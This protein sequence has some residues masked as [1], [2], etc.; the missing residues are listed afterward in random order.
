MKTYKKAFLGSVVATA[1]SSSCV[2]AQDMTLRFSH[3]LP[4]QHALPSHG[5]KNWMES[6]SESSNGSINFQ[7][8]PSQQLGSAADHYD[9]AAMGIADVAW[10]NTGY[11]AGRFPI[12]DALQLPF[13]VNNNTKDAAV[14]ATEWY[15]NYAQSEMSEVI[16][17]VMHGHYPGSLHSK[18]E[19]RS[20]EQISGMTIR[21]AGS[22]IAQLVSSLGGA[23]VQVPPP[24]AREALARGTADAITFPYNSARLFDI[25]QIVSYSIDYPIYSSWQAI[26]INKSAYERM[27]EEQKQVIDSHCT[28]EWARKV[29]DYWD[30]WEREG[31][32]EFKNSES[33]TMVK[34]SESEEADWIEASKPLYEQWESSVDSAGYDSTEIMGDLKNRL[35]EAGALLINE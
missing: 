3:Y 24:E 33:H 6:I 18:K 16:M 15:R 5:F 35:R 8:F 26:V 2:M 4:P 25:D 31:Y 29:T 14:A 7:V 32:E 34:L 19:V 11:T 20:P 1:L 23:S 12:A 28:G 10:I 17:C 30:D 13:L 22:S 9:M 27:G 21:P